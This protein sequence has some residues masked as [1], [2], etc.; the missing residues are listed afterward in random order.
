MEKTSRLKILSNSESVG[1]NNSNN[2]CQSRYRSRDS[3]LHVQ[4]SKKQTIVIPCPSSETTGDTPAAPKLRHRTITTD[5]ITITHTPSEPESSDSICKVEKTSS[6]SSHTCSSSG[7]SSGARTSKKASTHSNESHH[8]LELVI[9]HDSNNSNSR[10]S[11]E[12]N[13]EFRPKL[14]FN[15]NHLKLQYEDENGKSLSDDKCLSYSA[16]KSHKLAKQ[17]L[18]NHPDWDPTVGEKPEPKIDNI[19]PVRPRGLKTQP[20]RSRSS[21]D[22]QRR[23]RLKT[24]DPSSHKIVPQRSSSFYF[25]GHVVKFSRRELRS[26][27][28]YSRTVNLDCVQK[29]SRANFISEH[30]FSTRVNPRLPLGSRVSGTVAR[31]PYRE[32]SRNRSSDKRLRSLSTDIDQE[33]DLANLIPE[34]TELQDSNLITVQPHLF[35]ASIHDQKAP[36]WSLRSNLNRRVD[37]LESNEIN[38]LYYTKL[39]SFGSRGKIYA[40]PRFLHYTSSCMSSNPEKCLRKSFSALESKSH[41]FKSSSKHVIMSYVWND[42]CPR[43]VQLLHKTVDSLKANEG[44]IEQVWLTANSLASPLFKSNTSEPYV[45]SNFKNIPPHRVKVRGHL[46][47]FLGSPKSSFIPHCLSCHKLLELTSDYKFN[48]ILACKPELSSPILTRR[49]YKSVDCSVEKRSDS[50]DERKRTNSAHRASSLRKER[51]SDYVKPKNGL[52]F[53]RRTKS[54]ELLDIAREKSENLSSLEQNQTPLPDFEK[55]SLSDLDKVGMLG[56]GG[57]AKVRLV[58]F[59]QDKTRTYQEFL[60]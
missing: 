18:G 48:K 26:Q 11:N 31:L 17:P 42:Q 46:F 40:N 56:R 47:E 37:G 10:F 35:L 15:R 33:E 38:H 20:Q 52:F 41:K 45:Y 4:E 2:S 36:L 59:K 30:L 54:K 24:I 23:V 22:T 55:L 1:S 43:F 7:V 16:L 53:I 29:C 25:D 8:K 19:L 3:G 27:M 39:P 51:P 28:N 21:P 34:D 57:Y 12:N 44:G 58:R 49:H 6:K 60:I 14:S 9:S 50:L 32:K 13:E 5:A